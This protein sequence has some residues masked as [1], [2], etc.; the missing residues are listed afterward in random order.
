VQSELIL[1]FFWNAFPNVTFLFR[2]TLLVLLVAS[3]SLSIVVV[4]TCDFA[5]IDWGWDDGLFCH[6]QY[7][8][9]DASGARV[10]SRFFGIMTII[11][12]FMAI[13]IILLVQFFVSKA[14]NP[15][16]WS[17]RILITVS[18]LFQ[19]GVFTVVKDYEDTWWGDWE[20]SSGAVLAI[21]N[22]GLLLVAA[23]FSWLVGPP[24]E[25]AFKWQC[26]SLLRWTLL[27][28]LLATFSLSIVVFATCSFMKI[29]WFDDGIFCTD[30]GDPSGARIASRFF[31]I[32]TTLMLGFSVLIMLIVKLF[33][34]KKGAYPLWLS[35]RVLIIVSALFQAG[36]FTV[37]KDYYE[38]TYW[39]DWQLAT[40]SIIAII[41]S[42]LL[43]AAA[44]VSWLATPP[45]EPAVKCSSTQRMEC[46]CAECCSC[47][48]YCV[49]ARTTEPE[50][51]PQ[52]QAPPT[53]PIE[54]KRST[55]NELP[56]EV[57]ATKGT[58]AERDHG[59]FLDIES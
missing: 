1:V 57:E 52:E 18:A 8:Y 4:A 51:W 43:L 32:M 58:E 46:T 49:P 47:S 21:V 53:T 27:F 9:T 59:V 54:E 34:S 42:G 28:L 23:L 19:A 41:N 13:A 5:T 40:G 3:L 35:L 29:G 25:P 37:V 11:T 15:L 36:V 10:A 7:L 45:E 55:M 20:L 50:P 24:K 39:T 14:A 31:G 26:A 48:W 6:E 33:L 16:W 12:I 30:Y 17:L 44:A 2:W 22:S 38:D 56:P